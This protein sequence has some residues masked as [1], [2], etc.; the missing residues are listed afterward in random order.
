MRYPQIIRYIPLYSS[1]E[2]TTTETH[3][4]AMVN[5]RNHQ[6]VHLGSCS[7]QGSRVSRRPRA[8]D[9]G[10]PNIMLLARSSSCRTSSRCSS[11][12][13]PRSTGKGTCTNGTFTRRGA[14]A[15][16][17]KIYA[18]EPSSISNPGQRWSSTTVTEH[19][20]HL[21]CVIYKMVPR[22]VPVGTGSQLREPLVQK[23]ENQHRPVCGSTKED[24][25]ICTAGS[26]QA[27]APS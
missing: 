15:S 2:T 12:Y 24:P 6:R 11:R 27:T 26:S 3:L 16:E 22:V 23:Q 7:V 13:R 10:V 14:T 25:R 1:R 9:D 18:S 17:R 20:V 5:P 21:L 19:R 4:A 8:H